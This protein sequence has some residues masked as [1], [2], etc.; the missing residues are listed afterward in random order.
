MNWDDVQEFYVFGNTGNTTVTTQ[1]AN[2]NGNLWTKVNVLPAN[3]IYYE[4]TFV[5]TE[6]DGVK[7]FV[8]SGSWDTVYSD[9]KQKADQNT[10]TPEHQE[11]KE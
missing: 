1:D 10:E 5:T 2:K 7:G 6:S 11:T 9:D 4:D 8:Y 3:N